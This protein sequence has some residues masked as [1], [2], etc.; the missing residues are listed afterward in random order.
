MGLHFQEVNFAY[1]LPKSKKK[2]INFTLKDINLSINKEDEFIAV[3]GHT[4]SGKSTLVQLMNALLI[5]STGKINLFGNIVEHNKK[6]L[7]KSIRQRAG[8]VFQFP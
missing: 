4:G 7:L 6:Q 8:L 3:I 2:P 1:Y 5:P